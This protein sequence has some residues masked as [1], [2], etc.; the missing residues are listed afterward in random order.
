MDGHTGHST[1]DILTLTSSPPHIYRIVNHVCIHRSSLCLFALNVKR[2]TIIPGLGRASP[3][4]LPGKLPDLSI[5]S[6]SLVKPRAQRD[7]C[8]A[9]AIEMR[10]SFTAIDMP[11][12]SISLIAWGRVASVCVHRYTEL[13]YFTLLYFALQGLCYLLRHT[14]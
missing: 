3:P 7:L 14:M 6:A 1:F 8:V 10:C 12:S 4:P 11:P 13:L 9:P 2:L 5:L